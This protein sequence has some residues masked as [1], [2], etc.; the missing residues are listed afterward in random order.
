MLCQCGCRLR[1]QT[2]LGNKSIPQ[3][4]SSPEKAWLREALVLMMRDGSQPT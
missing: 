2:F 4:F 3:A 1:N